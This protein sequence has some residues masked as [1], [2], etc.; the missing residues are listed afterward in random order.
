VAPFDTLCKARIFWNAKTESIK[1]KQIRRKN[2]ERE[3]TLSFH[4]KTNINNK[5]KEEVETYI[6]EGKDN[7]AFTTL[8][9]AQR[10][11]N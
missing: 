5:K 10:K 7:D 2:L 9:V 6:L 3:Q 8:E 11:S 4:L 1:K